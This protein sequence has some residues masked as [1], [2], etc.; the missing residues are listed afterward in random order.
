MANDEPRGLSLTATNIKNVSS[1]RWMVPL[2]LCFGCRTN[3]ACSSSRPV[4]LC[5]VAMCPHRQDMHLS[6]YYFV[7]GQSNP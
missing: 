2:T 7:M 6:H 4:V 3:R 5:W 1:E